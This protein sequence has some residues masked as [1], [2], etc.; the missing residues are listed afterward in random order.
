MAAAVL[1][2]GSE[3]GEERARIPLPVVPPKCGTD[4]AFGRTTFYD[5]RCGKFSLVGGG[6]TETR[7][8]SPRRA[9]ARVPNHAGRVQNTDEIARHHGVQWRHRLWDSPVRASSIGIAAP[10]RLKMIKNRQSN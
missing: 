4:K 7:Y 2:P 9:N 5:W 10:C 8:P 6:G 3:K 1:S